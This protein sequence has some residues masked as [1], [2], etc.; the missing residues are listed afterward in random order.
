MA[1]AQDRLEGDDF[2]GG[3]TEVALVP[4]ALPLLGV[5]LCGPFV[6]VGAAT[7]AVHFIV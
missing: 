4:V 1:A 5:P 3:C 6:V 7:A 2:G